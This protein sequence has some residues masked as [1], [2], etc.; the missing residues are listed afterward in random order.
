[1]EE[2]KPVS[3]HKLL[4]ALI[5]IGFISTC[6]LLGLLTLGLLVNTSGSNLL[7]YVLIPVVLP[8]PALML[9]LLYYTKVKFTYS[10]RS[11]ERIILEFKKDIF[12]NL[13]T[14]EDVN[15]VRRDMNKKWHSDLK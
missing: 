14:R 8:L 6:T 11:V 3:I 10:M 9:V 2:P 7:F 5:W 15:W 1:M 12:G 4:K 13:H